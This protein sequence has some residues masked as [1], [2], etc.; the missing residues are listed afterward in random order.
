MASF[1][2]MA[3]VSAWYAL[4][5]A[6][7]ALSF[8]VEGPARIG[9]SLGT[10]FTLEALPSV[11]CLLYLVLAMISSLALGFVERWAKRAEQRQ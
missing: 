4:M 1:A 8:A 3:G 9:E 5:A 6:V 10:V 7:L 11:L 2:R